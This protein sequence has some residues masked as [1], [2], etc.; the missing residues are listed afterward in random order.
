MSR[1]LTS[2]EIDLALSEANADDALRDMAREHDE[3]AIGVLARAVKRK[4]KDDKKI[5]WNTSV[6][7]AAKLV[8]I[9]HGRSAI[10]PQIDTGGGDIHLTINKFAGSGPVETEIDPVDLAKVIQ[11]APAEDDREGPQQAQLDLGV[12]ITR[13][14]RNSSGRRLRKGSK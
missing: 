1:S 2:A 10:Q 3:D 8:E 11:E 12:V 13:G 14:K 9:G 4:G 7:A 6:N 5:P